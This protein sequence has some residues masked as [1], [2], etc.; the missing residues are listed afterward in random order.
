VEL[1]QV[2]VALHSKL[3]ALYNTVLLLTHKEQPE[4]QCLMLNIL[5]DIWV[6]SLIEEK[7]SS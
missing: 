2:V 6:L 1:L 7:T 5:M 3:L 4:D